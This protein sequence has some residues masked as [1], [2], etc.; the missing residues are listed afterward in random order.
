MKIISALYGSNDNYSDVL[1]IVSYLILGNE[2]VVVS[3]RFFG[4]PIP[5]VRKQ[6]IITYSDGKSFVFNENDIIKIDLNN[7]YPINNNNS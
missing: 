6:L 2:Y 5:G 4:D 3:N 7:S 1:S